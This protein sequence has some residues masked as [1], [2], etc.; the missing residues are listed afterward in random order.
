MK[1]LED[2][3]EYEGYKHVYLAIDIIDILGY[4]K[5]KELIDKGIIKKMKCRTKKGWTLFERIL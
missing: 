4:K 3:P 1:S 5:Y 2:V